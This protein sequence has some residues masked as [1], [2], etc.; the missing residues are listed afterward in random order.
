MKYC[1]S[2]VNER[3]SSI[4]ATI[5]HALGDYAPDFLR[6]L[7]E[8]AFDEVSVSG[9]GSMPPVPEQPADQRQILARHYGMTGS[10][11]AEVMQS[12]LAQ[13]CIR[14]NGSPA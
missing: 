5:C 7:N 14:A 6:C 10:G 9:S 3:A 11:M 8:V 12:Q 1:P 4:E 13:L 2:L